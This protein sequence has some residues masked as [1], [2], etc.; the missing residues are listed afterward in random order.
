MVKMLKL[1][2]ASGPCNLCGATGLVEVWDA[3]GEFEPCQGCKGTGHN[4]ANFIVVERQ[5]KITKFQ[6]KCEILEEAWLSY[7]SEEEYCEWAEEFCNPAEYW[8]GVTTG[9]YLARMYL[10]DE[11]RRKSAEPYVNYAFE[12]LLD[13]YQWKQDMGFKNLSEIVEGGQYWSEADENGL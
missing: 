11:A 1:G 4:S 8:K 13:Y 12:S 3:E 5:T 10:M 2:K 7:G 9:I 6:K